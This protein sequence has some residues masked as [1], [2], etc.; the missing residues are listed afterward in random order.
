MED[1]SATGANR[2]DGM[3]EEHILQAVLERYK[4]GQAKT[5]LLGSLWNR[6]YRVE[7]DNGQLYSLRL[8]PPVIQ[9]RQAVE[10]ELI[11]LEFVAS[12]QQVRV[13]CPVRNQQEG[14]VTTI[15]TG[16]GER[17]SCLFEWVEGEPARK[18]LTSSVM[19]QIGQAVG[20]LHEITREFG[21]PLQ[22][23]DFR[24][25]YRYDSSLAASHREWIEEYE[26]EIGAEK[27]KLLHTTVEWLIEEL[28]RIGEAGENFGFIHADLHFGNF[29]VQNGEVSVIDFDQLGRGHYLYDLAVLKVELGNELREYTECWERF[30]GGYRQVAALPFEKESELHPF[31]VAV[32]MAFLDWVYNSPNPVVRQQM[33]ESLPATYASIRERMQS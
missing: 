32:N 2:R 17:L 16:E 23:N 21:S 13:P 7:A 18:K 15:S 20:A 25:N 28:T 3:N 30:I 5:H 24:T 4:L 29:L 19:E 6:V 22:H 8:C 10:D 9:E 31:I 33:A 14:L 11:W 26:A 27:A 1:N 12:Q